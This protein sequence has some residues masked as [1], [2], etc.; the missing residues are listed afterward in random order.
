M[1]AGL[2][3]HLF[4]IPAHSSVVTR[5]ALSSL[6]GVGTH[7]TMHRHQACHYLHDN[8]RIELQKLHITGEAWNPNSSFWEVGSHQV[9]LAGLKCRDLLRS[10]I[11]IASYR[12]GR[13]GETLS[14]G[15]KKRKANYIYLPF[16]TSDI[17]Y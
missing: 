14:Q 3:D 10:V 17:L 7:R 1:S 2:L 12:I 15:G 5:E 8:T 11:Y 16:L 13:H 6:E 4:P 9:T